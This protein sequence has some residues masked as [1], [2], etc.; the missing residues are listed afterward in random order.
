MMVG[1]IVIEILK[2]KDRTWVNCKEV[3]KSYIQECAVYI[4]SNEISKR[5]QN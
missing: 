5:I 2:G 3:T 4:E 1:G